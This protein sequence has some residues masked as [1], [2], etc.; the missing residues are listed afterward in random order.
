MRVGFLSRILGF[1]SAV[2]V[3][4]QPNQFTTSVDPYEIPAVVRATQLISTDIARLPVRV[5][6]EDGTPVDSPVVGLL[7]R[8]AS[9]WQTGFD[10]RR[11][12][13]AQALS[14]GNG[15]ALIR[16]D[17]QG[18]V[19]ELTPIAAGMTTAL[20]D[21]D[22]VHYKIAGAMLEADQVIHIGCYPNIRNPAWYRS[23]VDACTAAFALAADEN[24]AHAGLI[25]TGSTGKISISHPGA[26]SD[27]TVEAIRD[28]WKNIHAT[29]EGAS[30]PLI[31]RE[32]MKAEKL[33]SETST[34][35]IESRRF[36]IQEIARAFGV[37]PELLYQQGGGA[38]TSQAET[39]RAYTEGGILQWVRAWEAEFTR[40]LLPPGQ[41]LKFDVDALLLG[42]FVDKAD[43]FQ[44]VVMSGIMAPNEARVRLGLPPLDD[45]DDP[46]PLM[47]GAG[48]G[49]E[50][51]SPND[52]ANETGGDSNAA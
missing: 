22:G 3:Y 39:M 42:N 25:K 37:P 15:I 14:S 23:P 36:S 44:K 13:T 7:T 33:S 40:K 28:A 45:L 49:A 48:S 50:Q 29:A 51:D 24:A 30:R 34:T 20:I 8:E 27:Q 17:N 18:E 4:A 26:M 10:F 9:R 47:P 21:D 1:Q 41:F 5:E 35:M 16:R 11:Y 31:L 2:V 52:A 46:K 38:L 19:V 6:T 12:L 43:A 32:G